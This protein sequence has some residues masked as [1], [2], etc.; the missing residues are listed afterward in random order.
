MVA[1]V[2]GD[3]GWLI[4]AWGLGA[5][6]S[7][8]GALCYAELATA[9]PHAGGD[10]YFLTRAFGRH[11]SFLYAWARSTVINSGSIALLAFVFG[12][13]MSTVL[14]LGPASGALWAAAHRDR[15]NAP[16]HRRAAR[17]RR[18]AEPAAGDRGRRPAGRCRRRLPGPA[19][20]CNGAR[21]LFHDSGARH[22]RPGDGLRAADLRRLERG[23]VYLGRARRV[24]G[25]RSCRRWW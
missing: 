12:D 24:A 14:S 18:H 4:V 25:A 8:A 17:L 6:V 23:R 21:G 20:R 7:L 15:A 16:Q 2:T 19:G 10:Y 22:V 9:Y 1:G 13:Y 3:V 11:T 5:V